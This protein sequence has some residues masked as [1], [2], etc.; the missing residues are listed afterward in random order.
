[1]E[2]PWVVEVDNQAEKTRT[3]P[4]EE[5]ADGAPDVIESN[6]MV[7]RSGARR[8]RDIVSGTSLSPFGRAKRAAAVSEE[9]RAKLIADAMKIRS[10]TREALGEDL[11]NA[12]YRA[13][14]GSDPQDEEK[15]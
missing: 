13:L 8:L 6:T 14:M 15:N 10:E 11:V 9:A 12:M 2:R 3:G 7:V 1:M 5:P 4:F